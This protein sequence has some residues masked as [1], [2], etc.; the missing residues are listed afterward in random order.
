MGIL[1][2][3]QIRELLPIIVPND[4]E[5]QELMIGPA[6][7]DVRVGR[8]WMRKYKRVPLLPLIPWPTRLVLDEERHRT[9]HKGITINPG[10]M[11]LVEMFEQTNI[12]NHLVVK[13][14][15]K[16]TMAR[17]GVNH[18][19]TLVDPG[20]NGYLT[21]ELVNHDKKPVVLHLGQSICQLEFHEMSAV[22]LKPYQGKYQG[23]TTVEG[24][25]A[26]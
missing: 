18:Y 7:L 24:A 17:K 16:S 20:W 6:S 23:A 25:K 15:M 21:M 1:A 22:P 10:E 14:S 8:N 13:I 19:S 11:V 3:W 5:R 9:D 4:D 26:D 12:P 2:D